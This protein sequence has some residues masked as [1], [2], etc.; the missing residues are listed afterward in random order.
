MVRARQVALRV[1]ARAGRGVGQV[2]AAVEQHQRAAPRC[3]QR[4]QLIGA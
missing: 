2:E 3:Q 4:A 1:G